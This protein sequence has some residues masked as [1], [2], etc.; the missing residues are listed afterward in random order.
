MTPL[1]EAQR[2]RDEALRQVARLREAIIHFGLTGYWDTES[3]EQALSE[4]PSPGVLCESEPVA[5]VA[6]SGTC[7]LDGENTNPT[8][9]SIPLYRKKGESP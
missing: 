6:E 5:W 2:E 1:Q 9:Y 7:V 4:I 8:Y 3:L